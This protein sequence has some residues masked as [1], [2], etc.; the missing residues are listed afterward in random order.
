M[1]VFATLRNT[2]T[3]VQDFDKDHLKHHEEEPETDEDTKVSP[4]V[5]FLVSIPGVHVVGTRHRVLSDTCTNDG[6]EL[7]GSDIVWETSDTSRR[8]VSRYGVCLITREFDP[9]ELVGKDGLVS[10]T[11]GVEVVDPEQPS[12]HREHGNLGISETDAVGG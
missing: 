7:V 1:L 4:N 12:L 3:V 10:V 9:R 6:T 2:H 8:N 5:V 11:E